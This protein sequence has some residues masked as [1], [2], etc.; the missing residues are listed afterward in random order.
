MLNQREEEEDVF[1]ED[2]PLLCESRTKSF[3]GE[4]E[5]SSNH[6]DFGPNEADLPQGETMYSKGS[7]GIG[8]SNFAMRLRHSRG[9]FFVT[10]LS[11]VILT[12]LLVWVGVNRKAVRHPLFLFLEFVVTFTITLDTLLLIYCKGARC[13]FCGPN[14][15]TE[16]DTA[17]SAC[18]RF[19]VNHGWVL[20]NYGQLCICGFCIAGF[21]VT[22]SAGDLEWE[23]DLSLGL[24]LARYCLL[25]VFFCGKPVP[26]HVGSRWSVQ[27]TWVGR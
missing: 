9:Y 5:R 12:V 20:F 7:V 16:E 22:I 6:C 21:V 17:K 11:I 19:M 14:I 10:V 4:K 8:E 23:E 25:F 13:F 15:E 24:L 27:S 2:A 26:K 1:G 18:A 3:C